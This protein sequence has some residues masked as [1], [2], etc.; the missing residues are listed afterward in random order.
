[1]NVLCPLEDISVPLDV[2][3]FLGA[4]NVLVPPLGTGWHPM[5]A[6]AK[7]SSTTA[8]RSYWI[9]EF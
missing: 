7:V 1:M 5:H 4:F 3:I 9:V 8:G 2:L 6:T